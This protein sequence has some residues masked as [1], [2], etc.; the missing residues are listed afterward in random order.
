MLFR[1]ALAGGTD[2]WAAA[3]LSLEA[4]I[5]DLADAVDDVWKSPY[6]DADPAEREAAMRAYLSWE[7]D[8]VEQVPR[9]GSLAFQVPSGGR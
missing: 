9:D 7:V 5:D 6:A 3:G 1:S 8:L 4:G 2:A